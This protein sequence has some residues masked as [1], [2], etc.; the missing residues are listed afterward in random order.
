MRRGLAKRR[1]RIEMGVPTALGRV[2][3]GKGRPGWSASE[4]EKVCW[5]CVL[6]LLM[7]FLRA[8]G[9]LASNCVVMEESCEASDMVVEGLGDWGTG[10]LV[11][12]GVW[13][14]VYVFLFSDVMWLV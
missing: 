13:G 12:L 11:G 8:V 14:F 9:A 7:V 1:V 3:S 10:G 4:G 2:V 5:N 6:V